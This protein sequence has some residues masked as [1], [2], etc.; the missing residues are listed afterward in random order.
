LGPHRPAL[1]VR[2]RRLM[3]RAIGHAALDAAVA[4]FPDESLHAPQR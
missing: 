2:R 4:N 3:E 1:T